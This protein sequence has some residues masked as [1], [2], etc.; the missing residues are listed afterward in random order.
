ML[1]DKVSSSN[2]F[3][4]VSGRFLGYSCTGVKNVIFGFKI[5]TKNKFELKTCR[6]IVSAR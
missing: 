1:L 5:M 2:G 6:V 3:K 4:F